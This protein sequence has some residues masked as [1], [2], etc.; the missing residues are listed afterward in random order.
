MSKSGLKAPTTSGEI[1]V[2]L[3]ITLDR[4][5]RRTTRQYR[6]RVNR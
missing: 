4:L 5:Q 6:P 2:T 1:L 3:G